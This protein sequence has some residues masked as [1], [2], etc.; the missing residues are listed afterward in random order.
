VQKWGSDWEAED[1]RAFIRSEIEQA[2]NF[3]SLLRDVD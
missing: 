1:R 3:L 2:H